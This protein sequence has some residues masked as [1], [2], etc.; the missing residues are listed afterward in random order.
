MAILNKI[1]QRSMVLI[2]VIA[3]ALFSFILT[4]LFKNSSMFGSGPATVVGEINGISI[5]Q[6]DFAQQ[7]E[8]R[9][10]QMG[11][12]SS[13]VQVMNAIWDQELRA[14]IF[15]STAEALDM[16]VGRKQLIDLIEQSLGGYEEFL[17]EDGFFSENKLNGFIA[18]LKQ[19]SPEFSFLGGSPIDYKAWTQF[20]RNLSQGALQTT[21]F[22]LVASGLFATLN[23]GMLA[24]Q[25]ENE[26]ANIKFVQIPF[27]SIADSL[28]EPTNAD[29]KDFINK[30][31]KEYTVD[32]SRGLQFVVF[33]ETPSQA[34]EDQVKANLSGLL[35]NRVV[36]NEI[37]Q[38]QDTLAGFK[39]TKDIAGFLSANSAFGYN[40]QFLAKSELPLNLVDSIYNLDKNEIYGPYK[41]DNYYIATKLIDITQKPDSVKVRHILIPFVGGQRADAS[42]TKT[43]AEAKSTADSILRV[44]K[45]NRSKFIDLLSLSSDVVS[46]EKEGV[47]DWFAYNAGMAQEFKDFSFDN[48]KGTIDVV[49]TDFGYHI[50]EILDQIGSQKLIKLANL[51]LPIEPSE[52]TIDE[53][54]N[55][56][57]KF[58]IAIENQDFNQVARDNSYNVRPVSGLRLLDENI[59]GFGAQRSVV[60]WAFEK[61]V[62]VGSVRRFNLTT[63]G[64]LIAQITEITD[65]G[66]MPLDKAIVRARGQILKNKK[67]ELIRNRVKATTVES[68]ASAEGQVVKTANDIRQNN[69]TLSGVGREPK[70]VG[71]AFA[72]ND[73]ET[74]GLLQGENGLYLLEMVKKTAAPALES[75][76]SYA[77][78]LRQARIG[79]VNTAAFN[80]LKANADIEDNRSDFY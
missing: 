37:T 45:N 53:V 80:A 69:P 16:L 40:D 46:N 63:G 70:I 60:K 32:A 65:E 12:N 49:R 73:G 75:Y 44:V 6:V 15:E 76:L 35:E 17:D 51:A 20:E 24:H 72:L 26:S 38:T 64:Y 62:K 58:E 5:S 3:M 77:A 67:A 10:R 22:N 18:N 36:F 25:M 52:A 34:D 43:D 71:A 54:F 61:D 2:I 68:L 19:I 48:S 21:Y 59:P 56:T 7:V 47:I 13:S 30:H 31:E 79:N 74:S 33:E 42:V 1:R 78:R 28:V 14:A 9:Q 29:V 23:E 4:D 39:N 41:Q 8:N 50:I 27:S 11:P 66:L 55:A 57:S